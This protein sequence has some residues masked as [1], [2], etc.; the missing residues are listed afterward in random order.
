[1]KFD[2]VE[3]SLAGFLKEKVHVSRATFLAFHDKQVY[4]NETL[5]WQSQVHQTSRGKE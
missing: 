4:T 1:M 5:C 2:A 3:S